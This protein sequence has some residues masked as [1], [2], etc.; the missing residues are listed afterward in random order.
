MASFQVT[1]LEQ[2]N[3]YRP[4]EWP[5][6][7]RRFERFRETSG[8]SDKPQSNQVNALLYCMGDAAE[9]IFRSFKLDETH[10]EHEDYQLVKTC[11]EK[12]FVKRRNVIFERA[13]FNK[14]IQQDG[15][16]VE[17]FVLALYNLAEHCSYGSLHDE[18]IRDRL[19]VGL[20]D[21]K[22]SETLQLDPDL[23][24]DKAVTTAR[25]RE[26]V[27]QQQEV[28]RGSKEGEGLALVDSIAQQ[29]SSRIRREARRDTPQADSR[30]AGKGRCDWCG[31]TSCSSRQQCPARNATC[32]KC[33]KRGHF[34]SVCRTMTKSGEVLAINTVKGDFYL[35]M[36]KQQDLGS[37]TW[38]S[39]LF[40][41]GVLIEFKLDTGADVTVIPAQGY[42]RYFKGQLMKPSRLLR[43]PNQCCLNVV[44]QFIGTLREDGGVEVM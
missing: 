40:L 38:C 39:S 23:T 18:M 5:K 24:L 12:H 44:G 2:F 8:L 37:K 19:V 30:G 31:R 11:F 29:S 43:G 16:S 17:S 34:Q 33:S 6:W 4:N 14:R 10:K 27:K 26:A 3:F 42:R 15:E 28:I 21:S 41:N 32:F 35:G 1:P 22:V 13:R 25:Q 36:I 9:D 7:V 20:Q